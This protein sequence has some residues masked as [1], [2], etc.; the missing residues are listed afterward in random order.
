M[1]ILSDLALCVQLSIQSL[2]S[3]LKKLK[4]PV[5]MESIFFF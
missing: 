3:I 4:S 1:I 5:E 2:E